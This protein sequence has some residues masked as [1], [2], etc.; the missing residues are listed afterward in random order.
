MGARTPVA[1][2]EKELHRDSIR[3]EM[4]TKL[5]LSQFTTDTSI[6]NESCESI[7]TPLMHRR[8]PHVDIA[9]QVTIVIF[10]YFI[11]NLSDYAPYQYG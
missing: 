1:E 4:D 2:E 8:Q 10:W 3:R 7:E 9:D 5:R 6:N 11:H